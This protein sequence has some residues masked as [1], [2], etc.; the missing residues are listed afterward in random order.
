MQKPKLVGFVVVSLFMAFVTA[1]DAQPIRPFSG[2]MSPVLDSDIASLSARIGDSDSFLERWR[3]GV[4]RKDGGWMEISFILSNLGPGSGH[5]AVDVKRF[6]HDVGK[7]DTARS[8]YRWPKKFEA[9][10]FKADGKVLNVTMGPCTLKQTK[11]GWRGRISAWGYELEFTLDNQSD[12]WK[13]GNGKA[14]YPQGTFHMSVPATYARFRGRERSHGGPWGQFSGVAWFE[15]IAADVPIY[16]VAEK[17]L[18]FSAVKGRYSIKYLEVFTP[19]FMG[20]KRYGWLVVNRG[21]KIVASSLAARSTKVNRK[22]EK[23]SP[24]HKVPTRYVVNAPTEKGLIKLE[25]KVGES[26][27]REEVLAKVPA[28]IRLFLAAFIQ[29][30]NFYRH[31]RFKLTLPDGYKLRGSRGITTFSPMRA[32]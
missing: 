4:F 24:F 9:G 11:S 5:S 7:P 1:V 20:G 31:S 8:F 29:P 26:I 21:K 16:N 19:K 22:R 32:H 10:N 13:P 12:P 17:W 6:A 30:V 18:S 28:L 3:M 23:K 14:V 25:V 2:K 27:F 15:H